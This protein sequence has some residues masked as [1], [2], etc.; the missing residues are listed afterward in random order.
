MDEATQRNVRA[1]GVKQE[2][3]PPF[4]QKERSFIAALGKFYQRVKTKNKEA[5]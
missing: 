5:L 4:W 1:I 3:F 2:D